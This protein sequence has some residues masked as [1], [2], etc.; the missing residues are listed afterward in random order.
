[1]GAHAIIA[2][3]GAPAV[4]HV[5]FSIPKGFVKGFA[6]VP[7]K[8]WDG[9]GGGTGGNGVAACAAAMPGMGGKDPSTPAAPFGPSLVGAWVVEQPGLYAVYIMAK[10]ARP[11]GSGYGL[12][13]PTF[14]LQVGPQPVA[15][16]GADPADSSSSSSTTTTTTTTIRT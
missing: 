10:V 7:R 12:L 11:D 13:A 14:F 2:R 1:M 6:N 9:R 8:G 5:H 4:W 16:P 3:V 15:A